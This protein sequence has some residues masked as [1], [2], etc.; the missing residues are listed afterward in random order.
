MK[1]R[2]I[3]ANPSDVDCA[4]AACSNSADATNTLG[5]PR[6][7]RSLMSCTLHDV[8]LPQSASASITTSHWMEISWRRSTGAG[9]ANVGFR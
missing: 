8:Q 3:V 5:T 9:L 6:I 1:T 4:S 7:S 2:A